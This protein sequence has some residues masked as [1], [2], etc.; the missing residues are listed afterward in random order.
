MIREHRFADT[1]LAAALLILVLGSARATTITIDNVNEPSVGFN[2][3]TTA[4]PVGGN[5]GTTVGQ[6]RLNVFQRAAEQWAARLDSPVEIKVQASMEALACDASSAVLG[7][8][9]PIS[10]ASFNV[11]PAG[12]RP[13]R[14]YVMAELNSLYGADADP[15]ND[16]I[17]AQFNVSVNGDPNCLGGAQW[18]YGLDPEVPVPAGMIPLLP[19]VFHELGHGLGFVSLVGDNGTYVTGDTI[20][21]WADYLYDTSTSKLWADMT[22]AE[23]AAS[24]TN[25][26]HLVW[27]GPRTN[28]QAAA[29][30]GDSH[31]LVV[32]MLASPPAPYEVGTAS[33]GPNVPANGIAGSVVVF[34][35]GSA[36]GSDGCSA[37]VN[38]L[39]GK[40]ALIDRGTCAFTEKVK[41]A[42]NA[43][44]IAAIIA[45]NEA[46]P[47]GLPLP[48][49]GTDAS[50]IIPA[51]SITQSLGNSIKGAMITG[52]EA[53]LG[54][55]NIGVDGGCVR[56]FAPNPMVSGSSVSHF[57][58]DAFPDLLMEPALN[59]SI[60]DHVDLTLP[61]FADIDWR[62]NNI[63]DFIYL[64]GF[65]P[66]ACDHVQP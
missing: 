38:N 7:S 17:Q 9:G 55:A 59:K 35:D 61:L 42:Q 46:D 3:A 15:N 64:D 18:W 14:A 30:L 40:I 66:N 53:T 10:A 48:L 34:D 33:F 13:H 25:D 49:G 28:K 27:T 24:S 36:P 19:V 44:A 26:P 57:H 22:N 65:D 8:A 51:Y 2:D 47:L 43:G 12:A 4:T 45:N 62:T 21:V 23:R 5:P 56:M 60:F 63:E 29:L 32:E 37:A 50:I 20:P 58:A 41:N 1:A 52:V 31:A 54:Y 16:D 11:E 6:Q 39:T